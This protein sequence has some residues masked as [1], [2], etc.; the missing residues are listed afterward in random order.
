M[1]LSK[2]N[3]S[4]ESIKRAMRLC[5]IPPAER[6]GVL[7][8][9]YRNDGRY[10]DAIETFQDCLNRYPDAVF[11]HAGLAVVYSLMGEEALAGQEVRRTLEMDRSYTVQRFATPNLYRDKSI[12]NSCADALRRAGMP[13]SSH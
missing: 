1:L 6:L 12:L 13:E 2:A 3:E 11:A 10:S 5:P 7:A 8:T 4:V 9:A